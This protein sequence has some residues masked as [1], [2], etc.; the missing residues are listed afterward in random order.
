[1]LLGIW[2]GV[3][4]F[5]S[6]VTVI[7]GI[8]VSSSAVYVTHQIYGFMLLVAGVFS[9]FLIRI[10]GSLDSIQYDLRYLASREKKLVEL[11]N[12]KNL[13]NIDEKDKEEK[14]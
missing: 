3:G 12:E 14:A 8:A 5:F 13:P 11:E 2:R 6:I 4:Y 9:I 10:I 1:M 7:G